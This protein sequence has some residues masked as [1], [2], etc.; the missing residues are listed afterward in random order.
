LLILKRD[1]SVF[2]AARGHWHYDGSLLDDDDDVITACAQRMEQE[3]RSD[4]FFLTGD[5]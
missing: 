4:R 5:E 2:V 3:N 1:E